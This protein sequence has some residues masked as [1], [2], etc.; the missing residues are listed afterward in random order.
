MASVPESALQ[1]GL[2]L[3]LPALGPAAE[4]A[5]MLASARKQIAGC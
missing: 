4:I 5:P 1:K 3:L 2:V